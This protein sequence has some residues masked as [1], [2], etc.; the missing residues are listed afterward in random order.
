MSE[1]GLS[2]ALSTGSKLVPFFDLAY[3]NEET[4]AAAYNNEATADAAT[5]DLDASAPDGYLTYGGGV[6][7]NLQGKVSGYLSVMET[8]NR[9]DFSETTL[10]GSLRLK[11]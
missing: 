4:T 5:A 1:A 2:I 10:S 7:L 9:E 6:I 3:V 8:T 11:F